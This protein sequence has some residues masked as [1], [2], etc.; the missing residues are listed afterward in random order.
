M[1]LQSENIITAL[2]VFMQPD[3]V[4]SMLW[5]SVTQGI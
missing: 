3:K 5:F 1:V 4:K 2:A